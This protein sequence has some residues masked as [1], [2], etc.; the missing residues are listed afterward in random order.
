MD[1]GC[2][3]W[4]PIAPPGYMVLGCVV[5][6]GSQ[7]PPNH[8]VHCLRSDLVT[9]TM[10]SECIFSAASGGSF[11]SGF[12]IWRLDNAFGSFY[13]HPVTSNPPSD[14]CFDLNHLLHCFSS[15]RSS[16]SSQSALD[17]AAGHQYAHELTSSE[18]AVSSEWDYLR[19]ISK[20]TTCYMSTPH[21]KRIWWDRGSDLRRPVSIWRPIP[22]P[23]YAILGDCIIEGLESSLLFLF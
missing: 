3:V 13:A 4:L 10:Y 22:R 7:P 1:C 9:S 14:S 6:G 23:G 17:L 19:S 18:N 12:S 16:P 11:T 20:A 21:F 2:S 8:I 15:H 5:H